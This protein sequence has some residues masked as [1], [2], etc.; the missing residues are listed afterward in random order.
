ML[1]RRI[2][3]CSI[4]IF[5]SFA[6]KSPSAIEG[7]VIWLRGPRLPDWSFCLK[8]VGAAS[9]STGKFHGSQRVGSRTIH[10]KRNIPVVVSAELISRRIT[11][12][13]RFPERVYCQFI[14]KEFEN[15]RNVT[16]TISLRNCIASSK[17]SAEVGCEY[18]AALVP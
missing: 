6:H 3:G 7:G 17:L 4:R 2:R 9:V 5:K 11:D 14:N 13:W 1:Q 15:I 12:F 16:R 8:R 10:Q 18:A